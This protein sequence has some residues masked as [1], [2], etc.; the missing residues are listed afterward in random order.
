M[1]AFL[2]HTA[3]V[4]RLLVTT[5]AGLVALLVFTNTL[6]MAAMQA[7]SPGS[8]AFSGRLG[9]ITV[10]LS[11]LFVPIARWALRDGVGHRG[12]QSTTSILPLGLRTRALAEAVA[13]L[14]VS[15]AVA[16]VLVV[17]TFLALSASGGDSS[18]LTSSFAV[19]GAALAALSLPHLMLASFDRVVPFAYRSWLRWAVPPALTVGGTALFGVDSLLGSCLVGLVSSAVVLAWAP[20]SVRLAFARP[21]RVMTPTRPF[22]RADRPAHAM[23][24]GDFLRGLGGGLAR[25]IGL[26]TVVVGLLF[27]ARWSFTPGVVLGACGLLAAGAAWMASGRP[28]GL[29]TRTVGGRWTAHGGFSRA[30][31]TL[32]IS[33]TT[34][35]RAVYMHV[36]SCSVAGFVGCVGVYAV[37]VTWWP[38]SGGFAGLLLAAA[39]T[40][41]LALCG[42]RASAAFTS[43]R[44]WQ[45]AWIAGGVA[46][47]AAVV[48][49]IISDAHTFPSLFDALAASPESA[50]LLGTA[51]VGGLASALAP[52]SLLRPVD[53]R[54]SRFSLRGGAAGH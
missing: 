25:G 14:V 20:S 8:T 2:H 42:I 35:A 6:P 33:K 31:S 24:R 43:S 46:M 51:L 40:A 45:F 10:V 29:P 21:H 13:V 47:G 11:L 49:V 12:R 53:E 52:V 28:L 44:P 41:S 16:S 30:W 48:A 27:T 1:T 9:L 39:G 23:L 50:A 26:S 4:V 37:S 18:G 5:R 17:P 36:L 19:S 34:F 15:F 22:R 7:F 54:W 32:P 3:V 38:A